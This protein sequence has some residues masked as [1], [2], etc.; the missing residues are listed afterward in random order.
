MSE[1]E[2]ETK[3]EMVRASASLHR[4]IA[5]CYMKAFQA[6][7]SQRLEVAQGWGRMGNALVDDV[8]LLDQQEDL[9]AALPDAEST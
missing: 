8:F 6:V 2:A 4:L 7:G 9:E 1:P 3:P 5:H